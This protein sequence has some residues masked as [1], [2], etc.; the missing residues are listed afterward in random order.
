[1]YL[2]DLT[3]QDK[4]LSVFRSTFPK[5]PPALTTTAVS[6]LVGTSIIEITLVAGAAAR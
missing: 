4:V 5:D 3:D 6:K 2:T 1:M